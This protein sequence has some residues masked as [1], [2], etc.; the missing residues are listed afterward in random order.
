M[1]GVRGNPNIER[2]RVG[3]C[4]GYP[5]SHG[6][7]Q[8]VLISA[9]NHQCGT[10]R[11]PSF[12]PAIRTK[13]IFRHAPYLLPVEIFLF[14]LPGTRCYPIRRTVRLLSDHIVFPSRY[15]EKGYVDSMALA[16]LDLETIHFR[17]PQFPT[18]NGTHQNA[19]HTDHIESPKH[20]IRNF[21][22]QDEWC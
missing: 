3:A 17:F 19:A 1:V 12:G 9:Y 10:L 16:I 2:W 7:E 13:E 6:S 14:L 8:V 15:T 22:P 11:K 21:L 4:L 5:I 18:W 20:S